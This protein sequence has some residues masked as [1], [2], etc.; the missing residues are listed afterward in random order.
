MNSYFP[1]QS[2]AINF[3]FE[4]AKNRGYIPEETQFI[5]VPYGKTVHYII[6]LTMEKSG[7]PAKKCL[8]LSLY[9]M[10]SGSYELTYYF[11]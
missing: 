6:P 7:N 5:H 11:N 9:R 1:T 3:S 10:E 2:S 4:A 8:K